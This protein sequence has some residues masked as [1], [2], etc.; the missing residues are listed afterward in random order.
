MLF[1]SKSH[2]LNSHILH[3][4]FSLVG[5]QDS[6]CM[7][8]TIPNPVAFRDLLADL[9]IWSHTSEDLQKMLFD[10]FCD[11]LCHSRSVCLSV[12]ISLRVCL[13]VCLSVPPHTD[14]CIDRHTDRH[15]GD[16]QS[17]CVSVCVTSIMNKRFTHH[18]A[19]TK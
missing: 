5:S 17:L 7:L 2:L 12:C 4:S 13:C 9:S 16:T 8:A 11:L 14:T 19:K 15:T 3:L 18:N 6:Q 1:R 10:H